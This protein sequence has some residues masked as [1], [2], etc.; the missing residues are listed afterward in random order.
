MRGFGLR[1]WRDAPKQ[2]KGRGCR[3]IENRCT[4]LLHL[5]EDILVRRELA[6]EAEE[7]LLL[8]SQRL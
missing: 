6:I 1:V 5:G 7:L 4:H 8:L 3:G 2:R